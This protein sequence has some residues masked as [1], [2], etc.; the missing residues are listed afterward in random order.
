MKTAK[1]LF[2]LLNSFD[3]DR[4]IEAK[5]A[6]AVGKSMMETV[7]AFSNEPG[8][9]GGYLLLGAKRVGMAGDGKPI[10]EP[11]NI[12]NSDKIQ[13]DFVAMCNSMFAEYDLVNEQKLALVFVREVGA[14]DNA[15]YRQLDTTITHA[16]ARLE[17]H[18]LCEL[19]FLLKKG[20][21]RNTYYIKTEK[22]VSLGEM[23]PPNGEKIPPQGGMFHGKQEIYH[24]EQEIYHGEE[25][26]SGEIYHGEE[27][28][29][30][31]LSRDSL[32]AELPEEL[33]RKILGMKK[34]TAK[35]DMDQIIISLCSLRP[36]S[37]DEL[38]VIL[39][40]NQKALKS[41]KIKA[42]LESKQLF[43]WIPEMIRHPQQKYIANPSMARSKTK[44][45]NKNDHK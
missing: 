7:C 18:K 41:F 28:I 38:K 39:Q 43:Y 44:N 20:Q 36:Y 31:A 24:G 30:H 32:I 13:S 23:L 34:W 37:I 15:T 2:K 21:G 33:K 35:E 22:V 8:L 11:E 1:E 12:G 29:Y 9:R 45:N 5:S 6:S 42:L 27:K 16:R 3:E 17:L 40:R 4:R 25:E 14:I 10:Y 19:G 26:K